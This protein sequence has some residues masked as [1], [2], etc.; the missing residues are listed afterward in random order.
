MQLNAGDSLLQI[1]EDNVRTARNLLSEMLEEERM[2][3]LDHGPDNLAQLR[4]VDG[5][6]QIVAPTGF[7][8]V[9]EELEVDFERLRAQGRK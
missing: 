5:R 8:E 1:D 3:A 2:V 6:G 9:D 7:A 4:V